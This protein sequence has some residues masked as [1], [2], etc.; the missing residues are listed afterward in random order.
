MEN[1]NELQQ[2]YWYYKHN[3]DEFLRIE[4]NYI[5]NPNVNKQ[6]IKKL[7]DKC[8]NNMKTFYNIDQIITYIRTIYRSLEEKHLC[9]KCSCSNNDKQ[10]YVAM[11]IHDKSFTRFV[12][13]EKIDKNTNLTMRCGGVHLSY[14]IYEN[15]KRLNLFSTDKY[16]VYI[17]NTL[18]EM[19]SYANIGRKELNNEHKVINYIYKLF[20]DESPDFS[21]EDI[22]LRVQAMMS[23]LSHFG[24]TLGDK[25]SFVN[26]PTFDKE[27]FSHNLSLLVKDLKPYGKIDDLVENIKLKDN[28]KKIIRIVSENINLY[29]NEERDLDNVLVSLSTLLHAKH[30]NLPS[31]NCEDLSRYLDKSYGEIESEMKLIK[32]IKNNIEN[33]GE[34]HE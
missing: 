30:Y 3:P 13:S 10:K 5:D 9:I 33:P 18:K 21:D 34:E 31:S 24:I 14:E 16:D 26:L 15:G 8:F 2:K 6:E 29:V 20:F 28:V 25:Y 22:E 1:N 7:C 17:R 32:T 19:R 4:I 11:D 12:L 27:P 23:I